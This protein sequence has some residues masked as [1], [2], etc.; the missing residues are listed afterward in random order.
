VDRNQ[1]IDPTLTS[2]VIDLLERW[3][4]GTVTPAEVRRSAV[5]R[6][7]SGTWPD[8]PDDHPD[9]TSITLLEFLANGR[10]NGITAEDAPPFLVML[11]S[12]GDVWVHLNDHFGSIDADARDELMASGYYGPG[13]ELEEPDWGI[14]V[15]DPED[16]R[17]A[18][19]A[20]LD[21][22]SVWPDI[23]ARMCSDA[24]RPMAHLEHALDDLLSLHADAFVDR[25]LEAA[26]DC[27]EAKR[28]VVGIHVD[29]SEGAHER[30]ESGRRRLED[31]LV[32]AGELYVWRADDDAP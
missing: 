21:P 9:N 19:G 12:P 17:I 6:W 3:E 2:F 8:L 10:A 27:P 13:T 14:G 29:G 24:N 5:D 25:I 22:E 31:E 16:R 4:A 7:E 18:R 1:P 23:R 30:F 11:R 26:R 32:A 28:L 20:H 15:R